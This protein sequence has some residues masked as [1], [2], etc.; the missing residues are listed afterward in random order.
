M[1]RKANDV[2]ATELKLQL[3]AG[4][5]VDLDA[6]CK[7]NRGAPAKVRIIRE[8][9]RVYIDAELARDEHL[10]ERFA[11]TKAQTLA[12]LD[13]GGNIRLLRTDEKVNT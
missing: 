3:D 9:I 13:A 1:S 2:P 10:A 12:K 6:F 4:L 5:A 7:S 8:A 11:A